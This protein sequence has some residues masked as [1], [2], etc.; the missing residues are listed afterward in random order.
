MQIT[1][2]KVFDNVKEIILDTFP[3]MSPDSISGNAHMVRDL[4][5][6]NIDRMDIIIEI[7]SMY[8]IYIPN[9]EQL[10]AANTLGEFCKLLQDRILKITPRENNVINS[11]FDVFDIIKNNCLSSQ[12]DIRSLSNSSDF[13]SD[14]KMSE[15]DITELIE[16][17]RQQFDVKVPRKKYRNL[18]ELSLAVFNSIQQKQ[19]LLAKKQSIKDFIKRTFQKTK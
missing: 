10:K 8:D 16:W 5:I 11:Q 2:Q 19:K 4:N 12:Y 9:T 17:C 13:V 6:H 7:E 1:Y 14:L 18:D 3:E 15:F